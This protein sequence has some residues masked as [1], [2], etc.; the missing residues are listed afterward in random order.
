MGVDRARFDQ[1]EN[2]AHFFL[3]IDSHFLMIMSPVPF[4]RPLTLLKW[5]SNSRRIC[6]SAC[7][8]ARS[9]LAHSNRQVRLHLD[10][11]HTPPTTSSSSFSCSRSC[12]RLL[13][14]SRSSRQV[15]VNAV[16]SLISVF[17]KNLSRARRQTFPCSGVR[18]DIAATERLSFVDGMFIRFLSCT[19]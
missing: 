18:D 9:S 13:H 15:E 8:L 7:I 19:S 5:F 10:V 16:N 1:P 11:F 17:R 14:R 2:S 3:Y 4:C 12:S 6:C